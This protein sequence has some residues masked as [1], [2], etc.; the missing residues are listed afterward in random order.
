MG[1]LAANW[2]SERSRLLAR[3]N[4]NVVPSA[5]G[6][7]VNRTLVNLGLD[8]RF[9]E[10]FRGNLTGRYRRSESLDDNETVNTFNVRPSLRYQFNRNLGLSL[11]YSYTKT[12]QDRDD[13]ERNRISLQLRWLIHQPEWRVK[14]PKPLVQWPHR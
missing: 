3:V 12:D 5:A 9:T 11:T 2:I 8:Y 13:D 10:K 7:L 14:E 4:H 1:D 6:Q